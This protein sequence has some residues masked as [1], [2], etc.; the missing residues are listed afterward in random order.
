MKILQHYSQTCRTRFPAIKRSQI[1]R[2]LRRVLRSQLNYISRAGHFFKKFQLA[3]FFNLVLTC[4]KQFTEGMH[5]KYGH[6]LGIKIPFSYH[7]TNRST[8]R[9]MAIC[10]SYSDLS[11]VTFIQLNLIVSSFFSRFSRKQLKYSLQSHKARDRMA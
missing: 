3:S 5:V 10:S 6:L 7:K 8:T 2:K 1:I 9:F 11:V 4:T